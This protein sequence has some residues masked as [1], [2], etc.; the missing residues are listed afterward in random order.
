MTTTPDRVPVRHGSETY[1]DVLEFLYREAEALDERRHAE[2]LDML[3]DDIRYVVP[4]RVTSAHSLDDSA[5]EDM[6]HFDEDRYSL[7]KRVAR[8]DSEYAWAENPPSRTRRFV[9]NVRAW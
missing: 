4:V 7:R 2:W 9:T 1:D 3:T 5:L 8:F 6:A